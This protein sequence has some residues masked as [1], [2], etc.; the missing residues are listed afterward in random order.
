MSI[1]FRFVSWLLVLIGLKKEATP[2]RQLVERNSL[3]G[4][5]E[6]EG[7]EHIRVFGAGAD[8]RVIRRTDGADLIGEGEEQQWVN[9]VDMDVPRAAWRDYW[10]PLAAIAHDQKLEEF[11]FHEHVFDFMRGTG[12]PLGAEQK[13]LSFGYASVGELYKVR[14]TVL[15]HWAQATGPNVGDCVAGTTQVYTNAIMRAHQRRLEGERQ[16]FV[17]G[18]AALMAPIDGVSLEQYAQISARAAQG[19]SQSE[20]QG[21]LAG[22]GLDYAA[23]DRASRGWMDRM[24]KDTTGT[25]AQRY[26]QAFMTNGQGKYGAS[27]Q[28]AAAAGWGGTAAAGQAPVTFDKVCEIQ[29]AMSAWSKSGH[30]VN[31][32]LKKHFDMLATDWSAVSTWWMTQMMADTRKFDD[33]NR[34]C[35]EYERRWSAQRSAG[36]GRPDADIR[37]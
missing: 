24:S 23:W 12:D 34:L 30:D 8:A 1:V 5:E 31:A 2:D 16:S 6:V 33:Y 27:M 3:R 9:T 4:L 13:L 36:Q 26:G 11:V 25:I 7:R 18:N 29:G 37:F 15:K 17:A 28:Q 21:V 10:G 19:M 14:A 20:L 32:M 35:G 22:Y